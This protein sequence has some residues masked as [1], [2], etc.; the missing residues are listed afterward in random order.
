[1]LEYVSIDL[2]PY[3]TMDNYIL[4]YQRHHWK[5]G[6]KIQSLESIKNIVGKKLFCIVFFVPNFIKSEHGSD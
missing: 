6:I 4:C 5:T 3:S 2:G 1:M